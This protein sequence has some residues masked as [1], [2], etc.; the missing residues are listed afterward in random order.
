MIKDQYKSGGSDIIITRGLGSI[1][2]SS[3]SFNNP[4]EMAEVDMTPEQTVF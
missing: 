2:K 4:L 3:S 1:P